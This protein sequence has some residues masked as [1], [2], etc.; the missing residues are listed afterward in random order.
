MNESTVAETET[1]AGGFSHE[2]GTKREERFLPKEVWQERARKHR[3]RV[4]MWVDPFLERRS[5][6][7]RH[8]VYDFLFEYYSFRPGQLLRWSPGPG[9]ILEGAE[10]SGDAG[11][12]ESAGRGQRLKAFPVNR[13]PFVDWAMKFLGTTAGRTPNFNCFGLHE[14]AMVYRE[15]A[16]RH[17]EVPLRLTRSDL[18]RFV[19]SQQLSC[20]HFDAFRF[21]SDRAKPRNAVLLE[22]GLTMEMDQPACVHVNMDL[23]RFCY[24]I[25]PWIESELL[26]DAFALAHSARELDMRA[27]PYDL[28]KFGFEP[29]PIETADGRAQ[30]VRLQR[31]IARS[32][33]PI[34]ERVLQAYQLIRRYEEKFKDPQITQITQI[35]VGGA[36]TRQSLG[37]RR[38]IK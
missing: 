21:F 12:W 5:R 34:R 17:Q 19:E 13:L 37:C 38:V 36:T 14:W 26:V 6:Q 20:T 30:Y 1:S 7:A 15:P 25:A 29:I 11:A 10:M 4:S 27:S 8:P 18:D 33:E 9:V 2:N 32:A 23:Y 22:R 31:E 3:T 28:T 16:I 35:S 24:K